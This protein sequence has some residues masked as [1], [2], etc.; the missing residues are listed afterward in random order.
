MKK[1]GKIINKKKAKNQINIREKK[2]SSTRKGGKES[3]AE[4]EE[5]GVKGG[6]GEGRRKGINSEEK[7]RDKKKMIMIID[8]IKRTG[9]KKKKNEK[10]ITMIIIK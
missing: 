8:L 3:T 9:R 2:K 1:K 4:L 6:K 10:N 7:V 5:G